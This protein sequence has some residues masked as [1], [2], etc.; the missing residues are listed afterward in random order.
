MLD[1]TA[2]MRPLSIGIQKTK[3]LKLRQQVIGPTGTAMSN[4]V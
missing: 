2:V 3:N 4:D 1:L